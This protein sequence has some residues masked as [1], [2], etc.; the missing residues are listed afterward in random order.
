MVT[1]FYTTITGTT[2]LVTLA[3]AK[4]QL[5]VEQAFEEE[6]EDIESYSSAAQAACEDYINRSISER[7]LVLECNGFSN[8]II[9]ERN[10]E[11]DVITKIEY[12]KPG[13]TTLTL[14]PADQYKLRKSNVIECF[15][16]K[17]LSQ[18]ETDKRDDAV[19][20][21]IKQGFSLAECPKPIIQAI[22]LRLSDFY[23]RREDREQGNSPASNNLLR[24][25]R[26][27]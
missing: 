9:F 26:K 15:D 2:A 21:T 6:N 7:N 24:P 17:F 3:Q 5:R 10:Y 20:V 14:L 8:E 27:F 25:Y 11:N 4:K 12:Y 23:E 22:K 19:I 16:I 18:P 1:H 13:E